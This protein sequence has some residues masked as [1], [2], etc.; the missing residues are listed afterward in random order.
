MLSVCYLT[1]EGTTA[2]TPDGN[3]AVLTID[4]PPVNALAQPLR[5]ALARELDVLESQAIS[6]L[7][8]AC[9][10]STFIAG[11]DIREMDGPALEPQLP[12]I[13]T[14]LEAMPF[15]VF[16]LLHGHT[17]GGGFELALACHYRIAMMGTQLGLPEVN[18]G[19]IPG[20]GG[21]LRLA[22]VAGFEPAIDF[23]C[24]GQPQKAERWGDSRLIHRLVTPEQSQAPQDALL[25]A[26]LCMYAKIQGRKPVAP[27]LEEILLQGR[28]LDWQVISAK[29]K[30]R[31]KGVN[32][33]MLLLDTLKQACLAPGAFNDAYRHQRELFLSLRSSIQSK[34]L[35]YG[36]FLETRV[37]KHA[38]QRV[39]PDY[40]QITK[41]GVI[42]A[43]NM[44]TG[45]VRSFIDAGYSLIWIE[46][47]Q[48]AC[49]AGLDRLRQSYQSKVKRGQISDSDV[50]AL[51]ETVV[52]GTDYG[53]LSRCE[54]VVEA[55][56]ENIEVKKAIFSQ[57]DEICSADAVMATNTSYLDINDIA[58]VTS[59]PQQ[60]VGLHFFSPANV[61]K[62]VEIVRADFTS[63]RVLAQMH[64][65]ALRLKKFPVQ[66][67]VCFGFAAN[68]MYTR[69]G[70]EVQQILLEGNSIVAV[71]GAM[72]EFGMAMGPLAV[73]DLSGI[74]IGYQARS[75]LPPNPDD[76]GFFRPSAAMVEHGRLGRKT[77][78]GFYHYVDGKQHPS[79]SAQAIVNAEST[80]LGIEPVSLSVADIQQRAMLALIS[81][82][83]QLL[84]EGIVADVDLVDIIWLHGYGFPRHR[85]GPVYWARSLG[86]GRVSALLETMRLQYGSSVWPIVDHDD[87]ELIFAG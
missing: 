83:I 29:V 52:T 9:A 3:I 54:L 49:H 23:A 19:L 60:V 37:K 20:A 2:A 33:P 56:F 35:R 48:G 28:S 77:Q 70:R 42:G 76:P 17:L 16:A 8:I 82:A 26:A 59:R 14:K 4:S 18:L 32:A 62:L 31:A 21:A 50:Q 25:S 57:L 86:R 67:G 81:E 84:K 12:D 39:K 43:G 1:A 78:A 64:Q 87:L 11:A 53:L 71:D 66:V 80:A 24:S 58:G 38:A 68:R 30:R 69:Y 44:G 46:Q 10:G 27:P 72:T 45:I 41:V 47:T 85:G 5:A 75:R 55:A 79:E 7:F 65:V 15:P 13:L 61:M 74:D 34:A 6:A 36:F 40:P 51:L 22:A 63:K 73:Q